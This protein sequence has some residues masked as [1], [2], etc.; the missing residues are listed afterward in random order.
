MIMKYFQN[1]WSIQ[2]K[3]RDWLRKDNG[4]IVYKMHI[5]WMIMKGNKMGTRNEEKKRIEGEKE[6]VDGLEI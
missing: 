5:S 3:G 2:T 4:L 6:A 1:D